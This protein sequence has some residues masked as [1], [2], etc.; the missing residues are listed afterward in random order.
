VATGLVLEALTA[1][2][3]TGTLG[4]FGELPRE[5]TAG[6]PKNPG[7]HFEKGIDSN[8]GVNMTIVGRPSDYR[9]MVFIVPQELIDTY[10]AS[11]TDRTVAEEILC[12]AAQDCGEVTTGLYLG[13]G[14]IRNPAFLQGELLDALGL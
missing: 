6:C 7:V 2:A 13:D 10:A 8:D 4:G 1:A 5:V 11:W 3:V 9:L 14:E 12:S